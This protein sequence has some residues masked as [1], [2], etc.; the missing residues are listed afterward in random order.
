VRQGVRYMSGGLKVYYVPQLR[1]T[2]S[3]ATLPT[4]L[5][6]A[7]LLRNILVRESIDIVHAHQ[8]RLDANTYTLELRSVIICFNPFLTSIF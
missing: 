2:Q 4:L 7:P 8:V 6:F 3:Q 1:P 5:L